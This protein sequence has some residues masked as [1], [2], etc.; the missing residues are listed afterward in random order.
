MELAAAWTVS[1]VFAV[2]RSRGHGGRSS[3]SYASFLNVL[4]FGEVKYF[5]C[6]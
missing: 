1:V 6:V 4:A 5:S 3:G 2:A